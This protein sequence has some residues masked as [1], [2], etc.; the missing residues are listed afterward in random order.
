LDRII[1][2]T[3]IHE[4]EMAAV[5]AKNFGKGVRGNVYIQNGQIVMTDK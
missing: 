1:H 3:A 4:F 5:S 2:V